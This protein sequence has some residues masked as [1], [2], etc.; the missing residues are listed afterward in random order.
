MD[1]VKT[2]PGSDQDPC[3]CAM[4]GSWGLTMGRLVCIGDKKRRKSAEE[5]NIESAHVR[6]KGSRMLQGRI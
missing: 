5:F 2:S 3:Q 4:W 6:G 1:R